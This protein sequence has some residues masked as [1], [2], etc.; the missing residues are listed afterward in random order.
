MF[1]QQYLKKLGMDVT[2][3]G[4]E[5][6]AYIKRFEDRD[7]D[8]LI[9]GWVAPYDPDVYSYFH[10]SAAKGGKNISQ[11]SSPEA[12]ALLEQG[13][14]ET[15]AAKRRDIY[16]KLQQMLYD[17]QPTVFIWH[18]VELQARSNKVGGLPPLAVAL[19]DFYNYS[20]DFA[21]VA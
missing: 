18:Q 14:A 19:G 12:D 9:D 7:F 5:W 4:Q 10:S 11:Y 8:A 20:D 1:V 13:R 6:N 3:N 16:T 15:D 21:R 2:A 17:D